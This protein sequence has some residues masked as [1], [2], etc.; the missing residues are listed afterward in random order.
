MSGLLRIT[1]P[2]ISAVTDLGR[3]ACRPLRAITG[4]ALDQYSARVSERPGGPG[5]DAALVEIVVADFAA[6]TSPTCWSP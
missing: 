5:E 6:F 3:L 4:G 2:G 1:R